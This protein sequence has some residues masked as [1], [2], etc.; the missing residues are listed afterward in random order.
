MNKKEFQETKDELANL[1]IIQM[2]SQ[3]P[4][5]T[6]DLFQWNLLRIFGLYVPAEEIDREAARETTETCAVCWS[7][8]QHDEGSHDYTN[9][10]TMADLPLNLEASIRNGEL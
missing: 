2:R 9:K 7:H 8:E 6:P 5:L 1:V 4:A 10:R 3:F